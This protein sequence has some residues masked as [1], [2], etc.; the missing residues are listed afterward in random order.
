MKQPILAPCL[1][2]SHCSVVGKDQCA[3]ITHFLLFS[4]IFS[5]RAIA[6]QYYILM[7]GF[8]R[9]IYSW[10]SIARQEKVVPS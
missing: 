7:S 10:L 1:F 9:H 2:R 8:A 5:W 3:K 6:S 4:A